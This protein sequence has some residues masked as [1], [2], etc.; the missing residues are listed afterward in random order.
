MRAIQVDSKSQLRVAEVPAIA[1]DK[2]E[3]LIEV[4]C[5]PV[6]P[7]DQMQIAGTYIVRKAPP[8]TPGVVG[9]G[10]VIGANRPGFLGNLLKG[11]T[12]VFAPGPDLPGTWAEHAVA[13]ASQ[14]VPLPG[15][16]KPEEGVNLL[17]NAMTAVAL[18]K[19]TK[20]A[21]S[22]ALLLTAAAGELGRMV[23]AVASKHEIKVINVVRQQGQADAL[24]A[25]GALHVIATDASDAIKDLRRAVESTGAKVAADAVSGSMPEL[26]LDV[27]PDGGELICFGRLSGEPLTFDP[28][29]YLVGKH[30]RV[31]GFDVGEW[32]ESQTK[33]SQLMAVRQASEILITGPRTKVQNAVGLDELARRFDELTTDQTQ[34]K[35]LLFP[36]R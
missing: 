3:L 15:K 11:K 19:V 27:L 24:R 31:R 30:Q 12:V 26:I 22:P 8:F 28:M 36:N 10:K 18:V 2:G 35:T 21:K 6:N 5:A 29:D 33:L 17:A 23:N 7:A 13:P 16:L 25:A 20:A 32:L 9:V 14:C 4:I 1:P 34:G